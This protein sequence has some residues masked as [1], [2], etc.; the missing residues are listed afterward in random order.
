MTT[1][2]AAQHFR[3]QSRKRGGERGSEERGRTCVLF[4][5]YTKKKPVIMPY[6]VGS[7]ATSPN[8]YALE[9]P[10]LAYNPATE[11]AFYAGLAANPLVGEYELVVVDSAQVLCFFFFPFFWC[12][13]FNAPFFAVHFPLQRL[14]RRAW[15]WYWLAELLKLRGMAS[16]TSGWWTEGPSP[17]IHPTANTHKFNFTSIVS[18]GNMCFGFSSSFCTHAR[19]GGLEVQLDDKGAMHCFDEAAFLAEFVPGSWNA[20]LTCIGGTMHNV[21]ASAAFGLASAD[22][23]GR[24]AAIA[25][26][27][28]A[29]AAVQR[30]NARPGAAAAGKM[31]AV[32][33][34]SA[35]NNTKEGA[36]SSEAAF[37]ESLI[38][39][40]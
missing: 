6:I 5:F 14:R 4:Y 8:L 34:H 10:P 7:Y 35:P 27:K 31:I 12:V 17:K 15:W 21:G 1:T 37:T 29:H 26:A 22:A 40:M 39:I 24:Q 9:H 20:V 18:N 19:T 11:K 16:R 32:E 25:F 2:H 33:I 28:K 3:M 13:F 38:E 36:S 30:W 23:D